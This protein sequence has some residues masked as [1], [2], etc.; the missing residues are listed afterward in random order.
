[1][2]EKQKAL[3]LEKTKGE[4]KGYRALW[5]GALSRE[6]SLLQEVYGLKKELA[7]LRGGEVLPLRP[8]YPEQLKS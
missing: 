6:L 1:M 5:E 8:R 4:V 3:K 2:A 7:R